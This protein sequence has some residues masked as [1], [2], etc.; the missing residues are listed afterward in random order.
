MENKNKRRLLLIGGVIIAF[1]LFWFLRKTPQGQ[2]VIKKI[3]DF[4]GFPNVE[5]QE[6][7]Y[8]PGS[9]V[10]NPLD[11]VKSS[12]SLCLTRAPS[13]IINTTNEIITNRTTVQMQQ[14]I[15]RNYAPPRPRYSMSFTSTSIPPANGRADSTGRYADGSLSR[16][17]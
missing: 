16:F 11:K 10:V 8:E 4:A 1:L 17:W 13:T 5:G 9:F 12:C 7:E 2:Q 14:A 15:Q 6:V 3:S